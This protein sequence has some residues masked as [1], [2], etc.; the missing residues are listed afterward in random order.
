MARAS[1]TSL[2]RQTPVLMITSKAARKRADHAVNS[3]GQFFYGCAGKVSYPSRKI[4]ASLARKHRGQ[5]RELYEYQC[6]M[7]SSWHIGHN[8]NKAG[9]RFLLSLIL[10]KYPV[11][12]PL[13]D[14]PRC[15]I[16][17]LIHTKEAR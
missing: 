2:S 12:T 1:P 13:K 5:G 11:M 6:N 9:Q 4:S 17:F 7:C 3:P 16:E 14:V 15:V 8:F 10:N